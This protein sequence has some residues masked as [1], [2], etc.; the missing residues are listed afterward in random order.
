MKFAEMSAFEGC[1]DTKIHFSGSG[2]QVRSGVDVSIV[3][4]NNIIAASTS[5]SINVVVGILW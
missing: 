2:S 4:A 1:D 5:P 3:A